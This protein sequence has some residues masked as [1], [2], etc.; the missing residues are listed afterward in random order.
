MAAIGSTTSSP[1]APQSQLQK[2]QLSMQQFMSLLVTQLQYQD[3]LDP[4]S[5]ADFFAQMAQLG[6]VQGMDNLQ[7]ASQLQEA[8][9]M[10][11]KT[12]T[13]TNNTGN[14]FVGVVSQLGM[15]SGNVSLNVTDSNGNVTQVSLSNIQSVSS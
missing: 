15:N 2:D 11:G 9:G 12:V 8:Q 4:M 1:P 3:P 10:L 14:M 5:N 7:Q 13:A 6:S